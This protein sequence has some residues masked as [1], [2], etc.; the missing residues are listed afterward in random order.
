MA[1]IPNSTIEPN[2]GF[3]GLGVMGEPMCLNLAKK[4]RSKVIG[5]DL[6]PDPIAR[7][8]EEGVTRAE[9]VADLA[10]KCELIFLS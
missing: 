8:A 1:V 9:S 3:V 2:I 5:F 6:A 10:D 4:A 7:L